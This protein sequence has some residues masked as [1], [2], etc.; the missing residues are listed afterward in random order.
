MK[1]KDTMIDEKA[2]VD[3]RAITRIKM[4]E[5][6]WTQAELS[7][8]LGTKRSVVCD[9]LHNRS[10]FSQEK[11]ERLLQLLGARF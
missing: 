3:L 11:I 1:N 7:K 2:R 9:W 4:E 10:D 6:E 5:N 8:L